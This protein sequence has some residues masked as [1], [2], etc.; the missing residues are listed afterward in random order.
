MVALDAAV[1]RE[2][3]AVLVDGLARHLP[4]EAVTVVAGHQPTQTG[5]PPMP[6]LLLNFVFD[7]PYGWPKRELVE[8]ADG[9]FRWRK[10]QFYEARLQVSALADANAYQTNPDAV[11]ARSLA[12]LAS[13]ILASDDVLDTLRLSGLSVLRIHGIRTVFV[14]N[15]RE[16]YEPSP[17]FDV[18][19]RFTETLEDPPKIAE[20]VEVHVERV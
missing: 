2:V 18:E 5:R 11:D 14:S 4:T 15:D 10:T 8:R 12:R 6:A 9:S 1:M 13:S 7:K 20:A 16:Q 3:R 17:S 19:V